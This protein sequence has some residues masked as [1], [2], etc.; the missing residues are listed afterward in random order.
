MM[1]ILDTFSHLFIP[2]TSRIQTTGSLIDRGG[3]V[4]FSQHFSSIKRKAEKLKIGNTTISSGLKP[5]LAQ[6]N[7]TFILPTAPA[8]FNAA[9]EA[10]V[11]VLERVEDCDDVPLSSPPLLRPHAPLNG[12]GTSLRKAK[13]DYKIEQTPHPFVNLK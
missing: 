6:A 10:G 4:R 5:A 12:H 13:S 8:L 1:P 7:L 11:V 2:L 9:K 3:I